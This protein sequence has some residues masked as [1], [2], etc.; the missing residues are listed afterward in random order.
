MAKK[1]INKDLEQRALDFVM[2]AY[3]VYSSRSGLEDK[4][5]RNDELYNNIPVDKNYEGAANL[6]V[7]ETRSACL[8]LIDFADEVLFATN[9]F[10]RLK[11]V[12]G[13]GDSERGKINSQIIQLQFEKARIRAKFRQFLENSVKYGF[14][15]VK[16]PYKYKEKYI[17]ADLKERNRLN[18]MVRNLLRFKDD[19]ASIQEEEITKKRIA[20]Y[21]NIDFEVKDPFKMYWDYYAKWE[22]QRCIIEKITDVTNHHLKLKE[23]EG[24]Y[25][26]I[27]K[28]IDDQGTGTQD[29]KTEI[30]GKYP[31]YSELTGLSG[32]FNISNSNHELLEVW[33]NFDID[34]DGVEEECLIVIADGKHVIRLE[35]NQFDIQEKPYLHNAWNFLEG[36]SLG[37]GVPQLT[38]RS[39]IA[40]NDF[41]N[42]IMDNI[43]QILNSMKI[44]DDLADI[45]DWQLKSRANGIIKS[46]TGVNAVKELPIQKTANEGFK[47]VAMTKED[48]RQVSGATVSLQ[49]LPAR[50]ETTATEIQTQTNSSSRGIF[51]KLRDIEDNIIKE[52]LRRLYSY[53][54]QYM[55]K[56]DIIMILGEKAAKT[57][58][59]TENNNLSTKEI[60]FEDYDFIPLGV[61]QIENKVIKGQQILN[62]LNIALGLPPG[63]VDIPKVVEKLWKY[64]GDDDNVLLPQPTDELITPNDENI[65][66][67]QGEHVHAKPIENHALHIQEH[68]R[69]E[70]PIELEPLRQEHIQEH[71][72]ILSIQQQQQPQGQSPV[73][74]QEQPRL[75]PEDITEGTIS[76]DL[77]APGPEPGGTLPPDF[78]GIV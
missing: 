53:N 6:F 15:I 34:G 26:N 1:K 58:F 8:T 18:K 54:L 24:I 14:G 72:S 59:T 3:N 57:I 68:Q 44:V 46:K 7:P 33:C 49:G 41:T 69:L 70:V 10:F 63:I 25:F 36:T 66:M 12:G 9:P 13:Y 35:V 77:G 76:R 40:L 64:I 78:G 75:S 5:R 19:S 38:E 31:H 52:M 61:T 60:L 28:V 11:G 74:P 55:S 45:P 2:N 39:Q 27:D 67:S 16:I 65:L 29:S 73:A 30:D 17:V 43:T 56:E 4:W 37:I 32:N 22:D 50:Y 21:D 51:A 71:M 62:F 47:A 48:I 23:K 20:L 42:Q